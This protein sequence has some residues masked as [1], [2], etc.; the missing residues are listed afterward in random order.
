MDLSAW[1]VRARDSAEPLLTI[2]GVVLPLA[3]ALWVLWLTRRSR[4]DE[5]YSI[6]LKKFLRRLREKKPDAE[7]R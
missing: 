4:S 2:S 1:F 5:N 3:F 7:R 6:E